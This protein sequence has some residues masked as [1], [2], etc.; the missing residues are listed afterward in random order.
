MNFEDILIV[1]KRFWKKWYSR[2]DKGRLKYTQKNFFYANDPVSGKHRVSMKSIEASVIISSKSG[3]IESKYFQI[4]R[5]LQPIE[6]AGHT[7][8]ITTLYRE[9]MMKFI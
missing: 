5:L 1:I 6:V 8:Q 3:N 4:D 7:S 9:K 2:Q